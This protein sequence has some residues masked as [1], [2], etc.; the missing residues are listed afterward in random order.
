LTLRCG[1]I[2][3]PPSIAIGQEQPI[4]DLDPIWAVRGVARW[5]TKVAALSSPGRSET[6]FSFSVLCAFFPGVSVTSS[7]RFHSHLVFRIF[8]PGTKL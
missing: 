8:F 3:L 5:V 2:F 1:R 6:S 4:A 7:G